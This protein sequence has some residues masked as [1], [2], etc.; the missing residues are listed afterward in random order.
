MDKWLRDAGLSRHI[1]TIAQNLEQEMGLSAVDKRHLHMFVDDRVIDPDDVSGGYISLYNI[2]KSVKDV[3][4][5]DNPSLEE[6][7]HLLGWYEA[8]AGI[9]EDNKADY[10]KW[11]E[12]KSP[13]HGLHE[14]YIKARIK[15]FDAVSK[16][17][18]SE[19]AVFEFGRRLADLGGDV[20]VLLSE[21]QI[22]FLRA[23]S[24][25]PE[26]SFLAKYAVHYADDS[27]EREVKKNIAIAVDL[28]GEMITAADAKAAIEK[29]IK[30]SLDALDEKV[31]V[32]DWQGRYQRAVEGVEAFNPQ[33]LRKIQAE[34]LHG[35]VSDWC[36]KC[37]K[38]P[39][40]AW[41]QAHSIASPDIDDISP[42]MRAAWGAEAG[43]LARNI[44]GNAEIL[45][46]LQK[47][48]GNMLLK[49]I[50][51]SRD[52]AFIENKNENSNNDKKS[53]TAPMMI[54]KQP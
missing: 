19:D 10:E 8:Q 15:M 49:I 46:R 36:D 38:S 20:G 5:G 41:L 9:I 40:M 4:S 16:A 42:N 24:E 48:D 11:L 33:P 28:I 26:N 47:N 1:K 29:D 39:V 31:G 27:K 7:T 23:I 3:L 12:L 34:L 18:T 32:V 14:A 45:S 53:V 54:K 6:V 51:D 2:E 50:A 22:G 17:V 43:D 13:S 37:E 52:E 21:D 44:V 30:P 25:S 35:K